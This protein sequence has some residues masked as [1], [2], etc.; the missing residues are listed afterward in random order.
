M[1]QE[2]SGNSQENNSLKKQRN[3]ATPMTLV[4]FGKL[5]LIL[6]LY[7]HLELEVLIIHW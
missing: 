3:L 4:S 6:I 7:H 1:T 2:R 5:F